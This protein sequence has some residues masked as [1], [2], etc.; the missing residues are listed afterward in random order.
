MRKMSA[1][2]TETVTTNKVLTNI[3]IQLKKKEDDV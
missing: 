2:L 1:V 3:I